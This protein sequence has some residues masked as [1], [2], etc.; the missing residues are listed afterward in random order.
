[1]K[2]A[3]LKMKKVRFTV[4]D[5]I[6]GFPIAEVEVSLQNGDRAELEAYHAFLKKLY[7]VTTL[8]IFTNYL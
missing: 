3:D 1:M 2:A 4:L 7:N 8:D 6:T 5:Q